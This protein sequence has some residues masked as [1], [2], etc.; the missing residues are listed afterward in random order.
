MKKLIMKILK[1][2]FVTLVILVTT[3]ILLIYAGV[4]WRSPKFYSV[5][6]TVQPKVPIM[7]MDEYFKSVEHRRP[8]IYKLEKGKGSVYVLGIQ[9]KKQYDHQIDSINLIWNEFRPEIALVEGMLGFY[10]SWFQDPVNRYGESGETVRLARKKNIPFY[11]WEPDK[12]EEIKYLSKYYSPKQLAFFYSLR[13]YL[14]NYRFGKPE[15]PNKTIDEYIQDRTDYDIIRNQVHSYQ[16]IDSIWKADFPNEKDWREKS[17]EYG[18]PKGYL[19]EIANLSNQY[20]DLHMLSVII[21]LVNQEKKVFVT[22]GSS[23][24]YRIEKS[25]RSELTELK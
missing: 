17:D 16:E 2:F 19:F 13:P 3:F 5:N 14:S 22:M 4:I 9:H 15:N 23:H 25:L 8:Y 24:A 21:D 11:T 7:S 6:N 1:V 12:N 18:W 10:I 20:R